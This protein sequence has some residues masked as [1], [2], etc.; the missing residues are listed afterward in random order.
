[1]DA[2]Q[3][4]QA[5]RQVRQTA[6]LLPSIVKVRPGPEEE[7]H[8]LSPFLIGAW[9][10][11]VGARSLPCTSRD[12]EL[13]HVDHRTA[14][15]VRWQGWLVVSP[16]KRA[17]AQFL[18]ITEQALISCPKLRD[19]STMRGCILTTWRSGKEINSKMGVRLRIP[20]TPK[21]DLLPCPSVEE[22]LCRLWGIPF[23]GSLPL[24]VEGF[25]LE[26]QPLSFGDVSIDVLRE[27]P[28]KGTVWEN[29]LLFVDERNASE[30]AKEIWLRM[31][32]EGKT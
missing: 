7:Y 23:N 25:P 31:R 22:Y 8:V 9:T 16:L 3:G 11:W 24:G 4:V 15:R 6:G 20:P 1:M 28:L 5:A 32:K 2:R 30:K 12:P 13:C 21:T 27:D 18:A 14:G 29:G 26:Q 10:H 17:Q 19:K